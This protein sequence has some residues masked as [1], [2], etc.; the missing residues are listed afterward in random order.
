M[1]TFDPTQPYGEGFNREEGF[2]R[3]QKGALFSPTGDFLRVG[4]PL[5]YAKW[6]PESAAEPEQELAPIKPYR[7]MTL[8]EL[9]NECEREGILGIEEG[10]AKKL[11][12]VLIKALTKK[13]GHE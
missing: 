7:N 3:I 12:W 5:E 13:T 9:K 6:E 4:D 11:R 10:N 8:D 1:R 2:H